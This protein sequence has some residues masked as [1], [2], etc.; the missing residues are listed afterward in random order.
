MQNI[1]L[2][3]SIESQIRIYNAN[4][5]V[6]ILSRPCGINYAMMIDYFKG[7]YHGTVRERGRVSD[8]IDLSS[9]GFHSGGL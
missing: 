7:G 3:I 4:F 9:G 8:R 6:L 5:A 1:S 2:A